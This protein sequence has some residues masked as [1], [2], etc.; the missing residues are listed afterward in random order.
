MTTTRHVV[1]DGSNLATEGRTLP[2]LRQLEEAIAAYEEEHPGA[3]VIVVVDAT[4]EHRIDSSEVERFKAAELRGEFVSPPAGTVGRGDA[5]ILRIAKRADAI[6]LSNDSFQEFHGEHPW[7]FEPGRLIGGKPVPAVGWIF[8]PRNPVR[9]AK[10]RA[11]TKAA[12]KKAGPQKKLAVVRPDGSKPKVGDTLT[13]TG[14]KPL[15]VHELA[16]SLGTESKVLLELAKKSK[17]TVTSHAST[18]EPEQADALRAAFA[19]RKRKA[20]D[21]AAELGIELAQLR[22]L[23]EGLGIP[24]ASA[25]SSIVQADVDR[26]A[27]AS[28]AGSRRAKAAAA[29]AAVPEVEEAGTAE[30][31]AK[32]RRR[33]RRR[34]GSSEAEERPSADA[35]TNAPLDLVTFLATYEIGSHLDGVVSAFTSHGA[36]VEVDLGDD[37]RFHCYVRTANLGDPPPTKARE[38]LAKGQSA[39]FEVLSLDPGRRVAELRLVEAGAS[40]ASR[41]AATRAAKPTPAT[42]STTGA[43]KA[44]GARQ[45]AKKQPAKKEPAKAAATKSPAKKAAAKKAAANRAPAKSPAAKQAPAK[46]PSTTKAA[47]RKAASKNAASS[48]AVTKEKPAAGASS[49]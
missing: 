32:R 9:G 31:G 15:R 42:S 26:L 34:P 40:S 37:R 38:V 10:S 24:V 18:L 43:S 30:P 44:R 36:M 22:E 3:E 33:R 13:P 16:K 19:A 46:K 20:K 49:G 14:P 39:T 11:A 5:F 21:V 8:T 6:V 17:M 12:A 28:A 35:P 48:K 7:L 27:A 23:A 45:P 1:V 2:S 47:S 25:A 4:F 41:P 29:V